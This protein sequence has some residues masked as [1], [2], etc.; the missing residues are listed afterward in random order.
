MKRYRHLSGSASVVCIVVLCAAMMG[1]VCGPC[2][3][4]LEVL[5]TNVAPPDGSTIAAPTTTIVV[6]GT[7]EKH[8]SVNYE[9]SFSLQKQTAGG[10]WTHA[11]S[12]SSLSS[13]SWQAGTPG[14]SEIR[15]NTLTFED[16][17]L[18]LGE[19]VF[20]VKTYVTW[21]DSDDK[22]LIDEEPFH[23]VRSQ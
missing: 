12:L 11:A 8:L 16:V 9:L 21:Y 22:A 7:E 23:Y 14:C 5:W 20:R 10:S 17:S 15:T 1:A 18:D 2:D 3:P 4:K 13:T 6:T 19:N